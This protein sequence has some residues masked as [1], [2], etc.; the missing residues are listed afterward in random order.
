MGNRR[1]DLTDYSL[2]LDPSYVTVNNRTD[3]RHRFNIG[4]KMRLYLGFYPT[5]VYTREVRKP[6]VETTDRQNT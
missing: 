6:K 3:I 4:T 5:V 2:K 1:I